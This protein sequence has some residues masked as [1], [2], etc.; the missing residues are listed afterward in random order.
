[1]TRKATRR[2]VAVTPRDS[3]R[4]MLLRYITF[5]RKYSSVV[6]SSHHPVFAQKLWRGERGRSLVVELL[7]SKQIAR[8]RFSPS[9]PDRERAAGSGASL[10][11]GPDANESSD[12]SADAPRRS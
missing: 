4:A 3:R 8:V 11:V 2:A 12:A 1:M 10:M 9:A 5:F 6:L 7:P